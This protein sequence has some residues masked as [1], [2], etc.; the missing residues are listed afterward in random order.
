MSREHSFLPARRNRDLTPFGRDEFI[1]PFTQFETSPWQMM[2]R[3]FDDMNRI[4]GTTFAAPIAEAAGNHGLQMWSPSVDVAEDDKEWR[5]EVDLPGVNKDNIDVQ[6]E[7]GR[8]RIRAEMRQEEEHGTD[9][10]DKQKQYHWRERRQGFFE[11][12]FTLPDNVDENAI[13][14]DYRDGVLVC[15]L[16]KS[17]QARQQGR[18]IAINDGNAAGAE[19][20]KTQTTN[21]QPAPKQKAA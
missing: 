4:F 1:T 9:E 3:M 13:R 8:L 12:V 5:I 19:T 21:A 20:Q 16:P 14:C 2:R 15:H 10:K 7:T 6:V 11:R 17:E 18:R